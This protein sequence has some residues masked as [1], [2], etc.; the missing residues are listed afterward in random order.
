LGKRLSSG[1][2]VP[3]LNPTSVVLESRSVG[4]AMADGIGVST[5]TECINPVVGGACVGVSLQGLKQTV[6]TELLKAS[7]IA[8]HDYIILI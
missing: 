2:Q 7:L 6:C 8:N 1:Q 4:R 5:G 3:R